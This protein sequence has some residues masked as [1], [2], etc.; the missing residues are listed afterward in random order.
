MGELSV[1]AGGQADRL[2]DL[3]DDAL[4]LLVA[5]DRQAPCAELVARHQAPVL[6][7]ASRFLGDRQQ[8]QEVTQEVFL[9]LWAERRRYRPR[10]KLRGYL[11]GVALNRCRLAARRRRTAQRKL[12]E[13]RAHEA[14]G[15]E[16]PVEQL[17][18]A[19]RAAQLHRELLQL[20]ERSRTA[21]ILRFVNGLSYEEMAATTGQRVG[22]LKSQVSRGLKELAARLTKEQKG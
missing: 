13:V 9:T 18:E 4:M 17:L 12:S 8:A 15:P 14:P 2:Q 1:V 7:F 6:A 22:T 20:S 10:G 11:L 5:G 21:V 19:E 16:L 3:S